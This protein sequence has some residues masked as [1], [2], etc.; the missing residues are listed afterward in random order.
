MIFNISVNIGRN[1]FLFVL[2]DVLEDVASGVM[3]FIGVG[4]V[5]RGIDINVGSSI[6]IVRSGVEIGIFLRIIVII[7]ISMNVGQIRTVVGMLDVEGVRVDGGLV[8]IGSW[9][10]RRVSFANICGV[11][12]MGLVMV[13]LEIRF[14]RGFV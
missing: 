3:I 10:V 8:C 6:V 4:T 9:E 12:K 14:S 5:R 2:V 7:N 1:G 11:A 13:N